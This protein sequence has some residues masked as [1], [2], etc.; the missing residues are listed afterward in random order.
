[1]NNGLQPGNAHAAGNSGPISIPATSG[2]VKFTSPNDFGR[3]NLR[4]RCVNSNANHG[5]Q[6]GEEVPVDGLGHVRDA[7]SPAQPF[8]SLSTSGRTVTVFRNVGNWQIWPKTG[9][10]FATG[11]NSGPSGAQFLTSDF[12][13]VIYCA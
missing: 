9:G 7:G 6:P 1:M 10:G 4:L 13:I 2:S 5:Y 12:V 3:A 11:V 8:L